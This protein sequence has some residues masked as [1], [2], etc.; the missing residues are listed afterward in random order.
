MEPVGIHSPVTNPVPE[1]GRHV[2]YIARYPRWDVF[3][4]FFEFFFSPSP[5]PKA[6]CTNTEDFTGYAY[7]GRLWMRR[8]NADLATRIL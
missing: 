4:A 1:F 6:C 5:F 7:L 8:Y 3:V 2:Q